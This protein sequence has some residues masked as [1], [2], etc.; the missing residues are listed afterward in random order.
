MRTPGRAAQA[1]GSVLIL[2]V[3]AAPGAANLGFGQCVALTHLA[4]EAAANTLYSNVF[5]D[6]V[7]VQPDIALL[8]GSST[9]CT[10]AW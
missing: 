10:C 8:S 3:D 6:A 7:P 9:V 1:I 4:A 2:G 5:Q